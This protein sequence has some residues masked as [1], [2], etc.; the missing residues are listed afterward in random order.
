MNSG[1]PWPR[2]SEMEPPTDDEER[3][4]HHLVELRGDRTDLGNLAMVT[5]PD[6]WDEARM[7]IAWDGLK[8]KGY[9]RRCETPAA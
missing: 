8:R 6:G 1:V 2:L 7:R 5:P 3:L 4:I 9:L